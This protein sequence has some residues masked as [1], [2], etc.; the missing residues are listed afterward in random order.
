MRRAQLTR[1][2]VPQAPAW[3][4]GYDASDPLARVV[5]ERIAL[6][7]SDAGLRL[8][9]MPSTTADLRLV[10][11]PLASWDPRVALTNLAA[12]LG[13][14]RPRFADD[15]ADSLYLAE[16]GL[17]QSHRV[18]PLL[19]LRNVVALDPAVKGWTEDP[20]GNWQ[21]ENVWL[22]TEKP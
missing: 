11:I 15:S 12:R 19:Y 20:D 2:E 18:I 13:M 16:S 8:Q 14:P 4:L 17:L 10:R 21:L 1:G 3:T 7:A 5:A 6:N 22:G 9:A